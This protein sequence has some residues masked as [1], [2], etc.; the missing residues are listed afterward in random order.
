MDQYPYSIP[1]SYPFAGESADKPATVQNASALQSQN[2]YFMATG[3]STDTPFGYVP[4]QQQQQIMSQT[5]TQAN[6]LMAQLQS[7]TAVNYDAYGNQQFQGNTAAGNPIPLMGA[8][9]PSAPSVGMEAMYASQPFVRATVPYPG[10]TSPEITA[11]GPVQP[12]TSPILDA[13][14][15]LPIP[16]DVSSAKRD[17]PHDPATESIPA[18]TIDSLACDSVLQPEL[19][20]LAESALNLETKRKPAEAVS[21]LSPVTNKPCDD[22]TEG[23]ITEKIPDE[24]SE[25]QKPSETESPSR[26]NCLSSVEPP[27]ES[28]DSKSNDLHPVKD[29]PVS[30]TDSISA[31]PEETPS[32][33]SD[34]MPLAPEPITAD[35]NISL[36]T[37]SVG[38]SLETLPPTS[39][40]PLND[41]V[42]VPQCAA[43]ELDTPPIT[44][45][46]PANVSHTPA[47]EGPPPSVD[48]LNKS[49]GSSKSGDHDSAASGKKKRRRIVQL[50]DDDDSDEA[51]DD[52][53]RLEL[54]RSPE[55]PGGDF[56]VATAATVES[57]LAHDKTHDDDEEGSDTESKEPDSPNSGKGTVSIFQN[58]VL[59]PAGDSDA[60]KRKKI[61][62]LD[63][64]DEDEQRV[65][66]NADDIGL[67]GDGDELNPAGLLVDENAEDGDLGTTEGFEMDKMEQIVAMDAPIIDPNEMMNEDDDV[68]ASEDGAKEKDDTDKEDGSQ[69]SNSGEQTDDDNRDNDFSDYE[70]DSQKSE[71]HVEE[72]FGEEEEIVEE[73]VEVITAEDE[74]GEAIGI[75]TDDENELETQ[76]APEQH[77]SDASDAEEDNEQR[78][79]D[80]EEQASE[81]AE[82]NSA[83]AEESDV[84]DSDKE[85]SRNEN[86]SETR[87]TES[88]ADQDKESQESSGPTVQPRK[89]QRE[90]AK[91]ASDDEVVCQNDLDLHTIS[92]LTDEEDDD[93]TPLPTPKRELPVVRIVNIKKELLDDR[94]VKKDRPNPAS[95]YQQQHLAKQKQMVQRKQEKKKK[96]ERTFDNNDPF[97]EWSTSSSEEEFIPNDIYFGTPDRVFTVSTKMRCERQKQMNERY[98]KYGKQIKSSGKRKYSDD[99]DAEERRK[100]KQQLEEI[101]RLNLPTYQ[102]M[103]LQSLLKKKKKKKR[104]RFYDKSQDIPNDIYFGNVNVPLHILHAFGSSSSEDER[105]ERRPVTTTW[106]PAPT[107]VVSRP[108]N[109]YHTSTK[110]S[111]SGGS[112]S[113]ST[114]Y[115]RSSLSPSNDRSVQAMKEYLKIAGF[116]NVKFHKLW[117]GCKSNQERANAILRLMQEKGLEGEPTIAKCRELRKQLQMEREAQ[118]LD[119][120]LILDAGEGRTTRR[121]LRRAPSQAASEPA[122]QNTPS[123]SN[124][125]QPAVV[126]P[127]G[128]ETL[129]RIR[130][131]I[132]PDSDGE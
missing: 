65:V 73:G 32:A 80:Q 124:V 24:S 95:Y 50:N 91:G 37:Q 114:S 111:R 117:E 101:S 10:T 93:P 72:E 126:P 2:P 44:S 116:K 7:G 130:N 86:Q 23:N 38:E 31:G 98:A 99:S 125:S 87:S 39:V 70:Q 29:V 61:R 75:A 121:S 66:D 113:G 3:A 76:P 20:N 21:Q 102:T 12:F 17:K 118:V 4:S 92:L 1:P 40:T 33:E 112:S 52:A 96:R 6:G 106:K 78:G 15:N 5:P 36:M 8:P 51:D 81:A 11:M 110:T 71:E 19:E 59:I 18:P 120:S 109:K 104:D 103:Q 62:V 45:T 108:T 85:E 42:V 68:A 16:L 77:E 26:L 79:S 34:I 69:K 64:D 63:S 90:S 107:T 84:Q 30:E 100:R 13:V 105:P 43:D 88:P 122:D 129:N 127:E 119:T 9:I 67:T 74:E 132:D 60:H 54:L 115:S 46:S 94:F 22:Q 35:E 83:V 57:T 58:V 25:M 56:D 27:S 41:A 48:E 55:P 14:Q 53:N 49:S 123:T 97:G 128:L 28:T 47:A 131:V 89:K 82:S